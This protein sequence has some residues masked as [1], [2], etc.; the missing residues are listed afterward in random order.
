[1]VSKAQLQNIS[2]SFGASFPEGIPS[3]QKA[4]DLLRM[5]ID[6]APRR[7]ILTKLKLPAYHKYVGQNIHHSPLFQSKSAL[8]RNSC[9]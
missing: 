2:S 7:T 9:R 4:K 8:G 5:N 6:V 3:E 1:M